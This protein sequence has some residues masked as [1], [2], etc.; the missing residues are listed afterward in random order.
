MPRPRKNPIAPLTAGAFAL[1][2]ARVGP[3]ALV[4]LTMRTAS[5]SAASAFSEDQVWKDLRLRHAANTLPRTLH[6]F[7][8]DQPHTPS[9]GSIIRVTL[10]RTK[11]LFMVRKGLLQARK[12]R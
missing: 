3:V 7:D 10:P 4:A 6:R 11:I 12:S 1:A 2:R 8:P 5:T 9:S